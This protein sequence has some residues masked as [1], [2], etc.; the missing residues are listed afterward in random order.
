M[1]KFK[2]S[3]A[4]LCSVL[5]IFTLVEPLTM[6]ASASSAS[7][8]TYWAHVQNYGWMSP[9]N[10]STQVP[11]E[12][13]YA[14]TT[15]E[16]LQLECL[17][18]QLNSAISGVVYVQS[19]IQDIGWTDATRSECGRAQRTGTEGRGLR[20]EAI[21]IWLD[22]DIANHYSVAYRTHVQ[23]IGWQGWV[24][25]GAT[26][27]TEGQS[28]RIEAIQIYLVEK[29]PPSITYWAHVQNYGWMPPKNHGTQVPSDNDYAGTTGE[30]LQLE[31]LQILLNGSV[32]GTVYAQSH[33]Q[34]IGWT[35]ATG[36]GCG[37]AQRTG[38]EGQSR[39][40]EAIRLWLDG[41]VA[42]RYSIEYRT[43]VQNI[44]WQGWVRDGG[45]AGT[46]GQSLRIEAIQI[47]LVEKSGGTTTGTG[48][49]VTARLDQIADGRLKYNNNTEMRVG[50]TFSGT[51]ANEQCKGYAKNVFY[52]CFGI[53]PGSTNA[54]P[55]NYQ[56]NSTNG[57][58][59]LGSK[60]GL[61]KDSASSANAVQSLFANA[62]PGDFVQIRRHHTGSHS[63]IVYSVTTSGVTFLEANTDG[64]NGIF[65][66]THSWTDLVAKN[67]AMSVYTATSYSLK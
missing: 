14:G 53:T 36:A 48:N 46:E 52:L 33:I 42:N 25:D 41:E 37:I 57:M 21:R 8:I 44:G 40:M 10:H 7:S 11:S 4:L 63:A 19:H 39:R 60:T 54:K 58:T 43:H 1:K 35:G 26:A 9:K 3:F 18:I 59:L 49:A 56:L 17:Q 67:Q 22:G 12:N 64:N 38:T 23:N 29:T 51:R 13:D 31:C 62:R 16:G 45:V 24:S 66:N 50:Q 28:L 65:R 30:G 34:D 61:Q 27:G 5:L 6:M 15:G 2:R 55:N 20:M 32:S 47:R